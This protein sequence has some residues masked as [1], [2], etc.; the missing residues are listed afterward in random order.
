MPKEVFKT[1]SQDKQKNLIEKSYLVF[2]QKTY[3]KTSIN[4]LTNELDITRTAF[5]YYFYNK[6]DLYT[7][8]IQLEKEA[9]MNN[10]IYHSDTKLL[11]EDIFTNLFIFL[12]QK[13]KTYMQAFYM[14]LFMN[15]SLAQQNALL[16]K[17]LLFHGE[18][19]HFIGYQ[20]YNLDNEFLANEI[21][22]ILFSIVTRQ[23]IAYYRDDLSLD[24]AK[25]QLSKKINLIKNGIKEGK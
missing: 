20:Y 4:D 6:D 10:Y 2:A 23:I 12:S 21:T 16:D 25:V 18:Y 22:L 5:Y 9:F 13:K 8:L 15:I 11:L 14:D 17:L 1:L 7:Y 3:H 24:E 19:S